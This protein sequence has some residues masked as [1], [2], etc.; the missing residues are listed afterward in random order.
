M[1]EFPPRPTETEA[2]ALRRR[3]KPKLVEEDFAAALTEA[4][5]YAQSKEAGYLPGWCGPNPIV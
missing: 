5:T 2:D 4:M 3:I 1:P